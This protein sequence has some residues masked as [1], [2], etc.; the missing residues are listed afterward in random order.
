MET[1]SSVLG[2]LFI[3]VAVSVL[4]LVVLSV[5]ARFV[6]NNYI[7]VPPHM[8]AVVSGRKRRM[9]VRDAE[10]KP[11]E[12]VV[13]YR[14]VKGGAT[15]IIPF[16]ER[17]DELDLRVIT[18]PNLMVK[19]AITAQGVKL[20][21]KAVANIKVGSEDAL[22]NNAVERLLGKSQE[23]IKQMAYE[24]LEGHLRSMLGTMTV[25]EVNRDRSTFQQ[26]M[27]TE[28]QIDLARLGLKIDVLTV[29]ELADESG[30]LD[31]LGKQRTAEVKRDA[32]IGEADAKREATI[33]A[34]TAHRE[35]EVQNQDN[36]AQEAEAKKKTNV[37]QADYLA[38]KQGAEARAAQAGPLA[39]AEARKAVVEKEQEV[40]LAKTNKMTEVAVAEAK[41]K[42]QELQATTVKPAEA[43]RDAAIARAKGEAEA[44]RIKAEATKQQKQLEGE[45]EAAAK[46]AVLLAEA[47]GIKAKLLAEAEGVMKKADAYKQLN[48]AGQ[49]L[50]I[51]EAAQTLVPK[52]IEEFAKV[53][54]AAA[55]P[56][57]NVDKMVVVDGGGGNSQNGGTA[58]QRL[59][60]VTPQMVFGLLQKAAAMG[61]DV[62]GLL[63]KAGVKADGAVVTEPL[64]DREKS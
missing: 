11:Q 20:T 27:I 31:A 51:L 44:I 3:P 58:L 38:E 47:A 28:S 40:E 21:V 9:S 8:V 52:S 56:L 32:E 41:R 5:V 15:L 61:I 36:L 22:L 35:G 39:T 16:L 10:G 43:E 49:L 7:K 13:G 29:K 1:A 46:Q 14:L 23:E 60:D 6:K 12:V 30:Y 62:S 17:K 24:T 55:A 26:K 42:E 25:E 18:I 54:A 19:D 63:A 4:L 48:E 45:G 37:K 53:M 33:K 59:A 50:Q 57:G 34:T 2:S 64:A